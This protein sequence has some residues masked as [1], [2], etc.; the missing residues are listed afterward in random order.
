MFHSQI[1]KYQIAID[2]RAEQLNQLHR[3]TF[4]YVDYNHTENS[5]WSKMLAS[6]AKGKQQH[7]Q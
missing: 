1:H 2:G 3:I 5:N 4:Q 6:R 7:R